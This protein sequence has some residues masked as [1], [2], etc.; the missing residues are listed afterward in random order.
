MRLD[1]FLLSVNGIPIFLLG[2]CLYQKKKTEKYWWAVWMSIK[3]INR[4]A[5]EFCTKVKKIVFNGNGLI[6]IV[7]L[8]LRRKKLVKKINYLYILSPL[9]NL[10]QKCKDEIGLELKTPSNSLFHLLKFFA[11]CRK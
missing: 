10:Q 2:K 8:N 4:G 5:R 6:N 1:F 9:N 7:F 3:S 11:T